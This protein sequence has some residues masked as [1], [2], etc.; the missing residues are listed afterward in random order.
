MNKIDRL[1]T[2]F[3]AAAICCLMAATAAAQPQAE[4]GPAAKEDTGN[5]PPETILFDKTGKMAPVKFPHAVHGQKYVKN[6]CPACHEGKE[7]LFA[8]KRSDKGMK[9][10][11]MYEGQACGA[12]H[13]GKKDQAFAAKSGCT[14]CHKK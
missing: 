7:P 2:L 12:C 4:Q 1:C 3:G 9:M 14:K 8:K 5:K 10:K 11:D 13:N 6:G